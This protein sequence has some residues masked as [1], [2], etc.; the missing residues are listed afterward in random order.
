MATPRSR[1]PR[2]EAVGGFFSAA[3]AAWS[4]ATNALKSKVQGKKSETDET[5]TLT[6]RESL[7]KNEGGEPQFL[8]IEHRQVEAQAAEDEAKDAAPEDEKGD[9]DATD[10]TDAN[11]ANDAK[12]EKDWPWRHGRGC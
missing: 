3:S 7:P 9:A 8:S 2:R 12:G 10:A 5:E 6:A 4:A 1:S 11:D